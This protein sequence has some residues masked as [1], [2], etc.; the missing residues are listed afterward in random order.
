MS[1][2]RFQHF[3]LAIWYKCTYKILFSII[4]CCERISSVCLAR[5]TMASADYLLHY[6]RYKTGVRPNIR[7]EDPHA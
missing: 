1:L 6:T 5:G 2:T 7:K 4:W 3:M